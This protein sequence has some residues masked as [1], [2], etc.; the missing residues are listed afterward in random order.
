MI[1]FKGRVPSSFFISIITRSGGEW[2]VIQ[3]LIKLQAKIS[4]LLSAENKQCGYENEVISTVKK[5][6]YR[7]HKTHA[8]NLN[9]TKG[10]YNHSIE[11]MFHYLPIIHM[12]GRLPAFGPLVY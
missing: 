6:R 11:Q 2:V 5:F 1:C 9:I 10:S 12:L 4:T 8:P 3:P 7:D